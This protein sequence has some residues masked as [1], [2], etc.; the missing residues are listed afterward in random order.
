MDRAG[1]DHSILQQ[2][3]QWA[4]NVLPNSAVD[5][6]VERDQNWSRHRARQRWWRHRREEMAAGPLRLLQLI[7]HGTLVV[8]VPCYQE[9]FESGNVDS[10]LTIDSLNRN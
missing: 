2:A 1:G 8:A 6:L 10:Q 7:N 4:P 9:L 3:W 5:R